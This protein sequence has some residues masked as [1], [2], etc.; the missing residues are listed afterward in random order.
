MEASELREDLNVVFISHIINA[1]TDLD[2]HWQLYSSG[3]MLD[4]TVN[5]DGLFLIFYILNARLMTRAILVISLELKP[6]V[7]ILVVVLT[8]VLKIN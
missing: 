3:K 7:T 8:D 1:G 2:E 6:T 5:I 4:R